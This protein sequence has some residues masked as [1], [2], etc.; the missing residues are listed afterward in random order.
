MTCEV[1]SGQRLLRRL[2]EVRAGGSESLQRRFGEG[3]FLVDHEVDDRDGVVGAESSEQIGELFG[4]PADGSD[5]GIQ[6]GVDPV[7]LGDEGAAGEEAG[8]GAGGEQTV[9]GR[10]KV[11]GEDGVFVELTGVVIHAIGG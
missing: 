11:A 6:F 8:V 2:F 1:E 3:A 5:G 9:V 10:G 4:G 7:V